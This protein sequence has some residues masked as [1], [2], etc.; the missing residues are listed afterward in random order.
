MTDIAP[1]PCGKTPTEIKVYLLT[2]G[3]K[4]GIAVPNCCGEWMIE[5]RADYI[6]PEEAEC[7]ERALAAW[8]AAP[9][10]NE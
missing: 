4:W 7:Q 3:D 2:Q 8:N 10:T 1:C 5:F 6:Q 9:R